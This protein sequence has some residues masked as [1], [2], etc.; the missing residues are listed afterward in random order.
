MNYYEELG[1]RAD[2]D[3]ED[4]RKAHRRLVKLMHPDHQRDKHMKLLAET[5]M[6]RLNTIVSTLLN[7][8]QRAQYDEALRGRHVA[9]PVAVKAW[10][11]VPWW[12]VGTAAAGIISVAGIWFFAD[13][14]GNSVVKPFTIPEQDAVSVSRSSSSRTNPARRTEPLNA[15]P[16]NTASA[17]N[18]PASRAATNPKEGPP[19]AA[20]LSQPTKSAKAGQS[21]QG[22]DVPAGPAQ[23]NRAVPKPQAAERASAGR[24]AP[25]RTLRDR[26]TQERPN[27]ARESAEANVAPNKAFHLPD[28]LLPE[29]VPSR[30]PPVIMPP[31]PGI[32]AP[33]IE[34]QAV[35]L[36]SVSAT[37]LA[38]PE[39]LKPAPVEK[40][41]PN[42]GG[43]PASSAASSA[44]FGG[45]LEGEW[46]YAPKEP[47]KRKAGFYPPQFID[48]KLSQQHQGGWQGQYNA[49]YE[50][51]GMNN[52]VS[53][54]VSF[55]VVASGKDARKFIWHSSNGS[56]GTLAIRAIDGRTIRIE[57]RT[58]VS[59]GPPALTSG[60]ATLVRR[61]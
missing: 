8:E 11:G 41:L 50:V 23:T 25:D 19:P 4:I 26:V 48:F 28:G 49:R 61:N 15:A 30:R 53:P 43:T 16:A 10:R 54:D 47:E 3:A 36:P 20:P 5:Q 38:K 17:N 18:T 37:L 60:I 33:R 35:S 32:A 46:V 52:P 55:Q 13:H 40:S 1:I 51:S 42:S 59:S 24:E 45:T 27:V 39:I 34:S 29:P 12:L 7:P 6:R 14:L 21:V 31:A 56:R 22:W 44:V 9:R 57:W 2:A 58:T